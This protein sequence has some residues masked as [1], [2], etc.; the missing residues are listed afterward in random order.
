[1]TRRNI[2]RGALGAPL[3]R[4][5]MP[6]L[7]A[8]ER[9]EGA[10]KSRPGQLNVLFHGLF[11]F[12][13]WDN[14]IEVLVPDVPNHVFL[15]GAWKEEQELRADHTYRLLG[16]ESRPLA[17]M[18]FDPE[19][20]AVVHNAGQIDHRIERCR[21]LLPIPDRVWAL[22]CMLKNDPGEFFSC[23]EIRA[24][25]L[26]IVTAL[27]Y[28]RVEATP[29]L[30]S[31]WKPGAASKA[32]NLHVWA[33]P[34]HPVDDTHAY[35]AL[36][37]F[38]ALFPDQCLDLNPHYMEKVA[39]MGQE[40]RPAGVSAFE[41]QSLVERA[42]MPSMSSANP[43]TGGGLRNGYIRPVGMNPE[44]CIALSVLWVFQDQRTKKNDLQTS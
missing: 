19:T 37:R 8:A 11:A 3:I 27:T 24:K 6:M 2:L 38:K 14:Y 5:A 15:A 23:N 25:K 20:S 13:T 16:V 42:G 29:S 32:T 36:K 1:M 40:P 41:E 31:L 4:F 30:G 7:K 10:A 12:V 22:R 9:Q 44:H 17:M 18:T 34:N 35:Q 21:L 33:E 43:V 28:D 26:P 39:G